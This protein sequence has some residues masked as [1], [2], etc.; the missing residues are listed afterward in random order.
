MISAGVFSHLEPAALCKSDGKYSDGMSI[1]HSMK[2][3]YTFNLDAI[4]PGT[5]F[6]PSHVGVVVCGAGL[7]AEQ[8]S[9]QSA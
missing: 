5:Y 1:N 9:K 3:G 6:A 7:I 8:Q 2:G 4:C